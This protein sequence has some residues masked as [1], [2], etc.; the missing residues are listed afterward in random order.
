MAEPMKGTGRSLCGPME[1]VARLALLRSKE[2]LTDL[3]RALER[4]EAET[5]QGL[6][7]IRA[8]RCGVGVLGALS[9]QLSAVLGPLRGDPF[10][11]GSGAKTTSASSAPSDGP[12]GAP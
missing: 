6:P 9:S 4:A 2:S 1:D 11:N 5:D 7:F 10:G 3:S 8:M 12:T